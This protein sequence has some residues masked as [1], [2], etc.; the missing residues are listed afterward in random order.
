MDVP[1][2]TTDTSLREEFR[3]TLLNEWNPDLH[4]TLQAVRTLSKNLHPEHRSLLLQEHEA[5]GISRLRNFVIVGELPEFAFSG[6]YRLELYLRPKN[7]Q[8]AVHVVNS[9]SV[10]ARANPEKCAACKDRRAAGT[11]IRGYMPLD[12][13]VILYLLSQLDF[14]QIPVLTDL[15]K[16]SVLVKESFGTRL[17]KPDGTIFASPDTSIGAHRASDEVLEEAK[18][19]DLTLHSHFV[20]FEP[21]TQRGITA[22]VVKFEEPVHHGL[23]GE[24]S[25]WKIF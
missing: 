16:L 21:V 20:S 11:Q 19:P 8:Q 25:G 22:P 3:Q 5:S 18:A 10:L 7:P 13:R 6:S 9:I 23:F 2:D 14:T 24:K 15:E 4:K 12:P 1:Y 17:V